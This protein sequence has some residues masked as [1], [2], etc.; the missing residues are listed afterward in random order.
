MIASGPVSACCSSASI[1]ACGWRSPVINFAGYSNRFWKLLYASRLVPEPIG[2]ADDDR[3]SEW[4]CGVTNIV[5]RPSLGIDAL[6]PEEYVAGR[7]RLR[8][9]IRRY[10]PSVVALV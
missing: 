8:A 4:G 10:R 5:P 3:L 9:T 7:T 6:R 2:Y 1:P